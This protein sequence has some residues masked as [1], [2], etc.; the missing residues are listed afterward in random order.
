MMSPPR[1]TP[2]GWGSP[3]AYLWVSFEAT[4]KERA[5]LYADT[6]EVQK[7]QREQADQLCARADKERSEF[8]TLRD[9][10]TQRDVERAVFEAATKLLLQQATSNNRIVPMPNGRQQ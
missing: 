9:Q 5:R 1:P 10:M 7:Q 3:V 2:L 8:V 4:Q 6:E